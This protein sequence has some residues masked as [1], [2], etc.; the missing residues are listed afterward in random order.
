MAPPRPVASPMAFART[1]RSQRLASPL[2][3]FLIVIM[4]VSPPKDRLHCPRTSAG[5]GRGADQD[6]SGLDGDH[7]G[8]TQ[9]TEQGNFGTQD[10]RYAATVRRGVQ[11]QDTRAPEWF[12][13]RPQPFDR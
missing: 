13:Q 6:A 8:E 7:R 2:A 11:V 3:G 9:V 10:L 12:G 4:P 1:H 5:T